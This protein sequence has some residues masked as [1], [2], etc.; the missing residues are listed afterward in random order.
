MTPRISITKK[1]NTL[2]TVSNFYFNAI[3]QLHF[4]TEQAHC[5]VLFC[6]FRGV[7]VGAAET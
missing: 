3:G 4:K 2:I 6:F 1:M 5:F 7:G